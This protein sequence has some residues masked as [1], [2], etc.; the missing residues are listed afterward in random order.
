MR[1]SVPEGS[2][3][4]LILDCRLRLVESF[5]VR[6]HVHSQSKPHTGRDPTSLRRGA[7]KVHDRNLAYR[8]SQIGMSP[9]RLPTRCIEEYSQ[10]A[11]ADRTR[12]PFLAPRPGTPRPASTTCALR[13]ASHSSPRAAL[14]GHL[15]ISLRQHKPEAR[16]ERT[17]R[18]DDVNHP[19]QIDQTWDGG[20]EAQGGSCA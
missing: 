1:S 9:V 5:P 4:Q 12:S 19:R 3:P 15:R 20:R 14:S 13:N 6:S 17:R 16:L 7:P 8:R 10:R 18:S 11:S 2:F